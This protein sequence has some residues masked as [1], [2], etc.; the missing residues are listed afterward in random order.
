ME[1]NYAMAWMRGM[2]TT[3]L[4]VIH[5]VEVLPIYRRTCGLFAS[6]QNVCGRYQI[7][8]LHVC[9]E[10]SMAVAGTTAVRA[11]R[12]SYK[13]HQAYGSG[14][15]TNCTVRAIILYQGC[16]AVFAPAFAG[17]GQE[18]V[19]TVVGVLADAKPVDAVLSESIALDESF[20]YLAWVGMPIVS[21]HRCVGGPP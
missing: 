16:G 2:F 13:R 9:F 12:Q 21:Y 19:Y 20:G 15:N 4:A 17:A 6:M 11:V 1:I 5:L 8:L 10:L 14:R 18:L 7:A 3:A